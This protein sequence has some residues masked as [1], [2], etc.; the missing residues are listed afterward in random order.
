ME[1]PPMSP[2][3]LTSAQESTDSLIPSEVP[4]VGSASESEGPRFN[5]IKELVETERKYVQ[6]L[7]VMQVSCCNCLACC[8]ADARLHSITLQQHRKRILLIKI[9][10]ISSSRD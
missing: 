5:I 10:Y 7:E 3:D 9:P 4:L 2:Q 8:L 6:D 1:S